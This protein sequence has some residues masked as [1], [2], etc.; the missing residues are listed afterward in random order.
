MRVFTCN[1]FIGHY[2]VGSAAIV[3]AD[4]VHVARQMLVEH[5]Q[6]IGLPQGTHKLE[7]TQVRTA[8][9][10]TIILVDGNH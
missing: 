5:L 1:N 10:T 4:D 8:K 9:P 6:A 7:L 2:P 3:V